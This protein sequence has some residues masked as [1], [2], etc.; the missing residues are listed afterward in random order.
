MSNCSVCALSAKFVVLHGRCIRSCVV[1]QA[2]YLKFKPRTASFYRIANAQATLDR[3][4]RS[5]YIAVAAGDVLTFQS[6]GLEHEVNVHTL[7]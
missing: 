2:S 1:L 3:V 5:N 7:F 6:D 4:L